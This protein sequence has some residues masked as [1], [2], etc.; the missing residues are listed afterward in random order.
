MP[1]DFHLSVVAPDKSVVEEE[2]QSVIA[3]GLEGYFGVWA[4]HIPLVA[5]LRPGLLEYRDHAGNQHFVYVGGGFAE[6]QGEKVTVLADEAQ[7]AR[8]IDISEA[9][10]TL[11]N[12]RRALRGEDSATQA[13]DAVL[14]IERAMSRLRAARSSR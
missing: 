10:R 8:E 1:R 13:E 7:L 2:V 9:E 11:E 5:A 4:G 6:V 14:E 12:A 3:P